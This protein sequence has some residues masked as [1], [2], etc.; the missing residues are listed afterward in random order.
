MV[1]AG[2]CWL[3][4]SQPKPGEGN[5][6]RSLTQEDIYGFSVTLWLFQ[7]GINRLTNA[8]EKRWKRICGKP[9]RENV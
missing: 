5:E 9:L 4:T 1:I 6:K 2:W 7:L 8:E 3:Q